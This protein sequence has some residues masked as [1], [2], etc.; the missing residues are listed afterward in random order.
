MK[1]SGEAKNEVLKGQKFVYG[2]LNNCSNG[3]TSWGTYITCE[4]N[5]DDFFG[6]SDENINFNKG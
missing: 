3:K 1:V 4:E 2:T 6:S 5:I